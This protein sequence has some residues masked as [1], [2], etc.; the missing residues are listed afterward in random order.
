M[1]EQKR[2]GCGKGKMS[3]YHF[4]K[5]LLTVKSALCSLISIVLRYLSNNQK[6]FQWPNIMFTSVLPIYPHISKGKHIGTPK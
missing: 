2:E 6:Y 3:H 5:I 4:H 1:K